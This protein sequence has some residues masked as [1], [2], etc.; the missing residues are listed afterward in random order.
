MEIRRDV[1]QAIA[2]P[3]RRDILNLLT[4]K[5]LNLNSIAENFE[6]S[7]PAISQHI[8]ILTECGLIIIDQ[9]GRERYCQVQPE[10]LRAVADW[11]EP[12]RKMWENRFNQLD[13]LLNQLKEDKDE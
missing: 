10:K 7:R 3:T 4:H 6:V 12:F 13:N 8:K 1:F 5:A 9:K 11:L 2:D